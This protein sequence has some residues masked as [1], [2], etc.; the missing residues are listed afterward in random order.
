MEM[1][2]S[3]FVWLILTAI[4]FTVGKLYKRCG[5]NFW[6]GFWISYAIGPILPIIVVFCDKIIRER[7]KTKINKGDYYGNKSKHN[8]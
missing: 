6:I 7:S 8:Y 2:L 5:Y 4:A 3:I 1:I